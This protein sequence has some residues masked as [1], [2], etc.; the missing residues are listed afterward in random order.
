MY[1]MNIT[2]FGQ[3]CFR[4]EAKEGSVLIDPF[5]NET[6]LRPPRIKDDLVLV[7][8]E[9]Y[10]HNATQDVPDDSFVIRGPGE[11]ER[12][13][14]S[15]RGI[16]SFH[17]DQEG[18]ERGFNTMYLI[19]AEDLTICH[20]GDL[21]QKALDDEQVQAIG[22]VDVLL[23]PVGGTYTIDAK[24]ATHVIAQIEPKIVVPMHYKIPKL[25]IPNLQSV[26]V[27]IKEVG[28]EAQ[29]GEKLKVSGNTLPAEET[30]LFVFS[31]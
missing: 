11:Y 18:A 27:F 30:Q 31:A 6:G 24:Q 29:K 25:T 4:V 2:W 23:I 14:I 26:D 19:K 15:V 17:D 28:L 20:L 3:S 1:A 5:S 7:T 10:D 12:K 13:G 21:G 22:N 16:A 9:H 8:H